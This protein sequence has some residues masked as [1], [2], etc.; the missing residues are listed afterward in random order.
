[1]LFDAFRAK[2]YIKNGLELEDLIADGEEL[3]KA[4]NR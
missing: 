3:A 2:N 1:V 4:S